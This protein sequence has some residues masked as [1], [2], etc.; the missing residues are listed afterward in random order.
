MLRVSFSPVPE[1]VVLGLLESS[2]SDPPRAPGRC[3]CCCYCYCYV[4]PNK[5]VCS[6]AYYLKPHYHYTTIIMQKVIYNIWTEILLLTSNLH[7]S[8]LRGRTDKSLIPA[9]TSH[10]ALS[11]ELGPSAVAAFWE[12]VV[13]S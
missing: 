1:C 9:E 7:N 2:F 10:R 3:H 13:F 4:E 5:L 8:T 12:K 11:F 6:L